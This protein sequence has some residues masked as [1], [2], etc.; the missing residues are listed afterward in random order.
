MSPRQSTTEPAPGD[1]APSR[2]ISRIQILMLGFAL[3]AAWG[4][5]MC[6][7]LWAIGRLEDGDVSGWG[8]RIVISALI[9]MVAATIFGPVRQARAEGTLGPRRKLFGRK[10]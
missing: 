4:V 10:R 5:V 7:V 3:G 2:Q 9:G 1:S 8:Y 6:A